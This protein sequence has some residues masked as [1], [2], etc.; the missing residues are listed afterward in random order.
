MCF[1]CLSIFSSICLSVL[2]VKC[3]ADS[4]LIIQPSIPLSA[5]LYYNWVFILFFLEE[6]P[7]TDVSN[8][9][10][11]TRCTYR[12]CTAWIRCDEGFFVIGKNKLLC[13]SNGSWQSSEDP[14][15]CQ[16]ILSRPILNKFRFIPFVVLRAN[17]SSVLQLLGLTRECWC[18]ADVKTSTVSRG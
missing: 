12:D 8:G 2:S 9:I 4:F 6:C 14:P 11:V 10:L 16:G 1:V 13:S 17:S 3:V 7:V 15:K 5:C 18:D